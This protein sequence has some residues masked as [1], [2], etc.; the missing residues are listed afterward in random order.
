MNSEQV[1]EEQAEHD[2]DHSAIVVD[3]NTAAL[4]V[5]LYLSQ[6]RINISIYIHNGTTT[7]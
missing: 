2:N 7:R 1:Y 4:L 3:R 5:L 6:H